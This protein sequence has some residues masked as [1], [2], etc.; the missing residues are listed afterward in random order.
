MKGWGFPYEEWPQDLKDEYAYN[1]VLAKKLLFDA[2][3]PDGFKTNIIVNA[4]NCDMQLVE[5]VKSYFSQIGID[6]EIRPMDSSDWADFVFYGHRHDQLALNA[7]SPYGHRYE[8]IRQL[9]RLHTGFSSNYLM[10][11]DPV[12]DAFQLKATAS[13]N[14]DEVKQILRDANEYIARQHFAI[15]L[16]SPGSFSLYQPWLKGYHGQFGSVCSGAGS[17]QLLFFYPARFWIDHDL[18]KSMGH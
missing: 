6:M 11:S 10:V 1:P 17:P 14:Q 16:L 3:Y 8:P 9:S 4:T 12:F 7:V 13:T 5:L 2:G 15:S 18:K